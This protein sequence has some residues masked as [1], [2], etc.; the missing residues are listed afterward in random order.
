VLYCFE[1]ELKKKKILA[2]KHRWFDWCILLVC[3]VGRR[4]KRNSLCFE[5][6]FFCDSLTNFARVARKIGKGR[7]E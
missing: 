5:F 7:L 2:K 3:F 1:T 6:I 4:T